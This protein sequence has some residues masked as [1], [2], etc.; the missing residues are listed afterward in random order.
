MARIGIV[1][2]G[3]VGMAAAAALFQSQHVSEIVLVDLDER[4]AQGEA[5]DLMHGQALVGPCV[6]RAAGYDQ[7]AGADVVIVTAG[8]SQKDGESR[9]ALLERNVAVFDGIVAELDRHAPEA[10]VVVATNPVD[11][12]TAVFHR[13]SQRPATH[14]IGTGTVL[15]SAR[16][17]A[18]L[19]D[20]Y[21]VDP[22]S[23]HAYVLGEH[24]DSE[25]VAWSLAAIGGTPLVGNEI[26][27]VPW[28]QPAMEALAHRVARAAYEIIERKGYTNWAIGAV[29]DS[30][31]TTIVRDERAVVPVSVP[32]AGL[33]RSEAADLGDLPSVCLSLP[34]R[35]GRD[36]A[37]GILAPPLSDTEIQA[38]RNSADT[39]AQSLAAVMG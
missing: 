3:H 21:G 2:T 29:I 6:V 15:D 24:G 37:M 14:V 17:R 13:A 31:V 34:T 12:M 10:I 38:L 20:H 27:G 8:V 1:G 26:L 19:G 25:F 33:V 30:L 4:S 23:V 16:L 28:D 22:Q 9:L 36:G 5:M 35:V 39:L 18:L 7:L 11:I 32:I